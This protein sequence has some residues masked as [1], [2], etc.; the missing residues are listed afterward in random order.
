MR[1]LSPRPPRPASSP[2]W[3]AGPYQDTPRLLSGPAMLTL[4]RAW[5]TGG[6]VIFEGVPEP[7]HWINVAS[8]TSVPRLTHP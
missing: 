3:R 1:A 2:A 6:R 8:T 4:K 7:A 5:R